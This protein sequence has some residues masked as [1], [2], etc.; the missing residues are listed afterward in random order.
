MQRKAKEEQG[1]AGKRKSK[2]LAEQYN[3]LQG[4]IIAVNRPEKEWHCIEK[5]S[6]GE[7]QHGGEKQRRGV[8]WQRKSNAEPCTEKQGRAV[9]LADPQRHCIAWNILAKDWH[10]FDGNARESHGV[11]PMR[12]GIAVN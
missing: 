2:G 1:G 12:K 4:N 6:K 10:G 5:R 8:E 7:A 11:A 9:N 3:D